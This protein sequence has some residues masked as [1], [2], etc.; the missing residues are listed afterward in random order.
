MAAAAGNPLEHKVLTPLHQLLRWLALLDCA[1][2]ACEAGHCFLTSKKQIFAKAT[3]LMPMSE[4]A[5]ATSLMQ[6]ACKC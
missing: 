4:I 5:K 3:S 2:P 6:Q 1:P